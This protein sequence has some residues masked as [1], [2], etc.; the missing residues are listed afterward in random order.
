[1]G[2]QLQ[3]ICNVLKMAYERS[4]ITSLD[5]N[6]SYRQKGGDMLYVTPSG[7]RKYNISPEDMVIYE[8]DDYDLLRVDNNLHLK[9]TGEF[10]LHVLFQKIIPDD[11]VVLHLHPTHII[12]AMHAG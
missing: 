10:A 12:A 4:W 6:A 2:S 9:P 7:V 11:R 8:I 5:G 1:M 3:D